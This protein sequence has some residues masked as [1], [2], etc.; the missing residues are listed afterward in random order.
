MDDNVAGA[1][2]GDLDAVKVGNSGTEGGILAEDGG[3][4]DTLVEVGLCLDGHVVPDPFKDSVKFGGRK[5]GQGHQ[6]QRL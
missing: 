5:N 2:R 6:C 4:V 3:E 1:A